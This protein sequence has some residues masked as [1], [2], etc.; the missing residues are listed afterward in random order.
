MRVTCIIY[1]DD[2]VIVMPPYGLCSHGEFAALQK[3][4]K[5]KEIGHS[6]CPE[7]GSPV[8][9]KIYVNSIS[10]ESQ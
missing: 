3:A 5:R 2:L 6:S 1:P 8:N 4:A 9:A 7:S 10:D